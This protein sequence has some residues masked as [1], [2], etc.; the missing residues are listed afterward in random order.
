MKVLN[1]TVFNGANQNLGEDVAENQAYDPDLPNRAEELLA[2]SVAQVRAAIQIS[3][4][5]PLSLTAGSVPPEGERYALDIAAYQLVISTPN[6]K[7]VII[8]DKGTSSPFAIFYREAMDWVEMVR[9]GIGITPPNDPCGADYVSPIGA[10]LNAVQEN[11]VYD[12]R[13]RYNAQVQPRLCYTW[14]KGANDADI[15]ILGTPLTENPST[16]VS[17]A[18][19]VLLTGTAGATVTARLLYDNPPIPGMVRIGGTTAALPT[20]MTT[21]DAP[22]PAFFDTPDLGQP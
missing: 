11:A 8:T 19:S 2:L 9:K 4:S 21:W 10:E 22:Q 20:D 1:L 6:L 7:M 13:G 15:Q 12:S 3:G 18:T 14:M 17:P 16:F 5:V